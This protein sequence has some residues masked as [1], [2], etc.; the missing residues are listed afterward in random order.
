MAHYW[1]D[2]CH[3]DQYSGGWEGILKLKTDNN[4]G[5]M[6]IGK[7]LQLQ[8]YRVVDVRTTHS[9]CPLLKIQQKQIAARTMV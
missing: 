6:L 7:I 5:G 9:Y 4:L 3:Q 1:M 8:R 2:Q